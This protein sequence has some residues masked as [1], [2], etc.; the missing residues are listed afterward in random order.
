M[1]AGATRRW[2]CSCRLRHRNRSNATGFTLYE[3]AIA[4]K[5]SEVLKEIAP[6]VTPVAVVRD[7]TIAAGIGQF[8]ELSV[9]GLQEAGEIEQAIAEFARGSNGGL[10]VTGE[11]IGLKCCEVPPAVYAIGALADRLLPW[12]GF[13]PRSSGSAKKGNVE[14]VGSITSRPILG[15][16]HHQYCRV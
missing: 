3:Y 13:L 12:T 7:P 8:V 4:A 1:P 15:G 16:L 11:S 6:G 2:S 10:I 9:A 14:R 5:W